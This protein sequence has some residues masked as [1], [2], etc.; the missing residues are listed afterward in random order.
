MPIG[1]LLWLG[2]RLGVVV[3][4][5]NKKRRLIAYSN[6]KAAFAGEKTPAELRA[7][8]RRVYQ[9]MVQT[10]VE[11]MNL[12]KVNRGYVDRYVEVVNMERIRDAAASGRGTVL[13]T[14]H[15]ANRR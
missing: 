1:I 4:A 10:F 5:F 2:R 11:V 12:T 7:I 6:L 3:F 13:L 14:A 8:T 15:F 9:N